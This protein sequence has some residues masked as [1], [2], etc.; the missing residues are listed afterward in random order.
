MKE[1]QYIPLFLHLTPKLGVFI[2][3]NNLIGCFDEMSSKQNPGKPFNLLHQLYSNSFIKESFP[4]QLRSI[5]E[6]DK[7]GLNVKDIPEDCLIGEL[8]DDYYHCLKINISIKEESQLPVLF[9]NFRYSHNS[10]EFTPLNFKVKLPAIDAIHLLSNLCANGSIDFF[11][12]FQWNIQ[13]ISFNKQMLLKEIAE[14]Y[15][16]NNESKFSFTSLYN[17]FLLYSIEY[18]DYLLN[19]L[20]KKDISPHYILRLSGAPIFSYLIDKPIIS[21]FAKDILNDIMNNQDDLTTNQKIIY[22]TFLNQIK[23]NQFTKYITTFDEEIKET[24]DGLKKSLLIP[25]TIDSFK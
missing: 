16:D 9:N 8:G 12:A 24:L 10:H 1:M 15:K 22:L 6:S 20:E 18:I 21:S 5:F 17:K 4:I 13:N 23:E 11:R 3:N 14:R 19:M 7:I 2:I 25:M